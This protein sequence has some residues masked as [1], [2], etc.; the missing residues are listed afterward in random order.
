MGPAAEP[1]GLTSDRNTRASQRLL[2]LD[3]FVV[4]E[5]E[6]IE[7]TEPSSFSNGRRIWPKVSE[8]WGS[9]R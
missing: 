7:H 8:L 3:Q 4:G 9:T 2:P 5:F 1:P 6:P